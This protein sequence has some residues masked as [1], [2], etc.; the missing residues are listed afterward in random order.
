MSDAGS[1]SSQRAPE[2][3]VQQL[4]STPVTS[5]GVLYS[6]NLSE[7]VVNPS[8]RP[9][10]A[11]REGSRRHRAP[12]KLAHAAMKKAAPGK[13]LLPKGKAVGVS[14]LAIFDPGF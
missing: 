7:R 4:G 13:Q 1:I 5:S 12:R 14:K 10:N 8:A 3:G 2:P 6:L 11:S 9:A